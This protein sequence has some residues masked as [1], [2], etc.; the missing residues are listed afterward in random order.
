MAIPESLGRQLF[1]MGGRTCKKMIDSFKLMETIR[2]THAFKKV[3]G[4][5]P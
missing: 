2:K 3:Q 5:S 1:E 4:K